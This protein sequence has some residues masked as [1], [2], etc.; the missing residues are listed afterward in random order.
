MSAGKV[1]ECPQTCERMSVGI[2]R[3]ASLG[4]PKPNTGTIS[5]QFDCLP[6]RLH[7]IPVSCRSMPMLV[8]GEQ[9][10]VAASGPLR[11]ERLVRSLR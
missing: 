11:S 3:E 7:N 10:L 1:E 8:N 2:R 6:G 5:I 4:H 9:L